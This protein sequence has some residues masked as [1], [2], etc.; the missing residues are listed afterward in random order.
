[1]RFLVL[2]IILPGSA[3]WYPTW[4]LDDC[5]L[6]IDPKGVQAMLDLLFLIRLM[7]LDFYGR[8]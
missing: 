2:C 8:A 7:K 6:W 5:L 1:M 4:T 3:A